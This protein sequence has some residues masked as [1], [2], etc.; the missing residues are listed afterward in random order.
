VA[1]TTAPSVARVTVPTFDVPP[2][3]VPNVDVNVVPV[4]PPK[5]V[6]LAPV[7]PAAPTLPK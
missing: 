3:I 1:T 2:A 7:A 4:T 5:V 6:V